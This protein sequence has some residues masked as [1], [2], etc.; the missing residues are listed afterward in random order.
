M[1]QHNVNSGTIAKLETEIG[2]LKDELA[3]S[4]QRAMS[5]EEVSVYLRNTK[6]QCDLK[7]PNFD[8]FYLIYILANYKF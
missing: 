6:Y 1:A 8:F 3:R 2:R 7:Q 5:A 4:E